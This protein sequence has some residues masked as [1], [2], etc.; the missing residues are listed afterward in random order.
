MASARALTAAAVA[1]GASL[2]GGEAGAKDI[3]VGYFCPLSGPVAVYGNE[4]LEA[5]RFALDEIARSKMLGDATI[6]LIPAD[7]AGNPGQAAQAVQRMIDA[8]EVTAVFGGCTSPETAAAI[9]ITEAAQVPLLSHLAQD[10]S[11]T[12][13]GHKYFARISQTAKTF[14]ANAAQWLLDS[15]KAKSVT[16]L[17]RND[18]YGQSLADAFEARAKE[19]GVKVAGR[20]AY[21]P[22]GREFKPIL[23]GVAEAKPDFVSILG[24][25]T[26]TGLIVKQMGELQIKIPT[27]ANTSPAIKQFREIAGPAANGAYGALYYFAGSIDTERGKDFVKNW[28]AKFGR[29]PTQYE[30]M[31]YDGIYVLADAIKR[32][33]AAGKAT[34]EGIRDALLATKDFSGATGPITIQPNGDVERPLPFVQLD[35]DALKLDFLMK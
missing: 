25:Y 9:E 20:V 33:N 11:L 19:L 10:T 32:A 35:G 28:Q 13:K 34:P 1:L 21:E 26:D 4:S 30:G 22:N 24:F 29:P 7:T 31:G 12:Q 17:A 15:H 6:K 2:A 23:A 27:F 5:A 3:K 8:D 16:I 14:S 18:N